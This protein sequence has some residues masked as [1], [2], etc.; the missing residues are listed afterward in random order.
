M[1]IRQQA[2]ALYAI[3]APQRLYHYTSLDSVLSI[4][5]KGQLW[6]SEIRF[7]SDAQELKNA[8]DLLVQACDIQSKHESA[9]EAVFYQMID[10]IRW[11][12]LEGSSQYVVCFSERGNQLSQWRGYCP[13]GKGVSLGFNTEHLKNLDQT[14]QLGKC[15]YERTAQKAI[16]GRVVRAI[17]DH[18]LE[19]GRTVSCPHGQDYYPAFDLTERDLFRIAALLK[20]A[21]FH[22]ECEWRLV[23]SLQPGPVRAGTGYRM[24][25]S[26][27]VPYMALD[28]PHDAGGKFC[29]D[30]AYLGPTVHTN[31]SMRSFQ[32]FFSPKVSGMNTVQNSSIPYRPW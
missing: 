27:L 30:E 1:R 25:A 10:W 29:I 17:A 6:A 3:P 16:A 28:L 23:S 8:C 21:A 9:G 15:I 26:M 22:E 31:L 14:F 2:D 18:A 19:F 12:L 5:T 24:G 7:M 20:N 4:L 32:E 13:D 11:R